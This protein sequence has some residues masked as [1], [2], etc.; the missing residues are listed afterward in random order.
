[1][2]RFQFQLASLERLL[3]HREDGAK[4]RA[5]QAAAERQRAEGLL[6]HLEAQLAGVRRERRRGRA[7]GELSPRDELLYEAYAERMGRVIDRQRTTV[8][9]AAAQQTRRLDELR[10]ASTRRRAIG[11]LHERRLGDHDRETQREMTRILDEVGARPHT[12]RRAEPT[13]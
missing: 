13:T 11:L 2:K 9:D 4:L 1:V 8:T 3:V 12:G 10:D 5:A 6:A 7:G